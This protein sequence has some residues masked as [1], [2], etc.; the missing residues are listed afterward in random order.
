MNNFKSKDIL[1]NIIILFL[2][3]IILTSINFEKIKLNKVKNKE[4]MFEKYSLLQKINLS[5]KKTKVNN[6]S[7]MFY[8]CIIFQMLN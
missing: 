3:Y 4:S 2:N 8:Y 7:K 6:K 1:T 5:N